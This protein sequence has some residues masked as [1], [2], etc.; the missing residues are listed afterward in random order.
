MLPSFTKLNVHRFCKLDVPNVFLSRIQGVQ[1]HSE[2]Q[3][4]SRRSENIR[5]ALEN[6]CWKLNLETSNNIAG[7][8][9]GTLAQERYVPL[10]HSGTFVHIQL[11]NSR[12]HSE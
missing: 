10:K 8:Y 7:K 3:E 6:I 9:E 1:E 4:R 5:G 2:T 11:R 12:G